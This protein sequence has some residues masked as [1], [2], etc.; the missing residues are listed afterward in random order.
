MNLKDYIKDIE[1]FP[2]EWVT[3]KDICPLLESPEA[4]NYSIDKLGENLVWV[5]KIVAL[6]ARWFI[7]G[8]ALASKFN[9]PFV[10]VRKVWKLPWETV[11]VSYKLEYWENIFE[12]QKNSIRPWEKIF[13]IDDLLAT[14]WTVS[15]A[16]KLIEELWWVIQSVNFIINLKFLKWEE[17]IK[18][19]KI[20][21]LLEY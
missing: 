3:F 12:M 15:A 16:C 5:D 18:D 13:I 17:K 1:D 11:K 19:Y 20:N 7:F 4:F 10:P 21:S 8:W 2:I 14:W 6:D 9:I